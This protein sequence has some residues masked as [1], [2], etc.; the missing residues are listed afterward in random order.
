ME[1]KRH[2]ATVIILAQKIETFSRE[3]VPAKSP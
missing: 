1:I 3:K 2:S